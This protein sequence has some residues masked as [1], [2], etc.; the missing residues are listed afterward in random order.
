M[1]PLQQLLQLASCFTYNSLCFPV[2]AAACLPLPPPCPP[3]PPA[4]PT[5]PQQCDKY[6]KPSE[7]CKDK[8]FPGYQCPMGEECKRQSMWFWQCEPKM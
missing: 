8:E 7:V 4:T 2:P 5:A 6:G 3:P 1:P